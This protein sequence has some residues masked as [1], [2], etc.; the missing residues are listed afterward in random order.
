MKK[1]YLY[2][3]GLVFFCIWGLDLQGQT[4]SKYGLEVIDNPK[5]YHNMVK[6]NP[7]Y[8]LVSL[9]YIEGLFFDIR[10][11]TTNNFT[12]EIIY[13]SPDAFARL[14]VARALERANKKLNERGLAIKVYDAYRPYSATVKFYELYKDTNYVASPYTGSRH[15]RGCA[16][17][18]TLVDAETGE[19][20]PMPTPYDDFSEK[21][22][23]TFDDLPEGIKNN[24]TLL[25][26]TMEEFGFSVYPTEW[27]HFDYTGWKDFP[28]MDLSF[29]ALK[30]KY[31]H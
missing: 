29:E 23:P 14:Q 10:Y 12:N 30:N 13:E 24:R 4:I 28:I 26:K 22:H 9:K 7:A 16:V 18:I 27:W 8:K 5:I 19:E 3:L 21:A 6:Q 11:A 20:L 31:D 1:A 15:N 17:D 2:F 25:I